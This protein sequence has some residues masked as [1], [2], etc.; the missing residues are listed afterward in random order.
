MYLCHPVRIAPHPP[1]D[2][3]RSRLEPGQIF[4]KMKTKLSFYFNGV[5][6]V[7]TIATTTVGEGWRTGVVEDWTFSFSYVK[8]FFKKNYN[9]NHSTPSLQN[10]NTIFFS[11]TRYNNIGLYL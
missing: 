7:A 10:Y 11:P 9:L 6:A 1:S 2:A 5:G 4:K 8:P 3:T